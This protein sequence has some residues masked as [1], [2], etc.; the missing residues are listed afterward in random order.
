MAWVSGS[1]ECGD[2][3][4]SAPE[5]L[6]VYREGSEGFRG[7]GPELARTREWE[8]R[9]SELCPEGTKGASGR[10]QR[11]AEGGWGTVGAGQEPW[12]PPGSHPG[13]AGSS[14]YVGL[15]SPVLRSVL[16]IPNPE[17]GPGSPRE[18]NPGCV[19]RTENPRTRLHLFSLLLQGV[20]RLCG[21][22]LICACA[23]G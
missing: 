14:T 19:C 16:R 12:G 4:I 23:E 7:L 13:E 15:P 11:A 2:R 3:G 1:E 20:L 22:F 6:R 8:L 21:H 18:Q 9:G 10:G 17:L 5:S